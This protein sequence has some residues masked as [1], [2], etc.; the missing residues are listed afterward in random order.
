[1]KLNL[2]II[3]A[4]FCDPLESFLSEREE[5]G[6]GEAASIP[7]LPMTDDYSGERESTS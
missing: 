3:F 6:T 1:M 2:E 4:S 7:E 5:E